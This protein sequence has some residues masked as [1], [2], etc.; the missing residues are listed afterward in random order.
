[1]NIRFKIFL[2]YFSTYAICTMLMILALY[3]AGMIAHTG[4]NW[5][6][7]I[8][9][10]IAFSLIILN[11]FYSRVV[12]CNNEH[13]CADCERKLAKCMSILGDDIEC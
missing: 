3:V 5:F 1:M 10:V 9:E 6:G 7:I 12:H 8:I 13:D 11:L 4:F 2:G